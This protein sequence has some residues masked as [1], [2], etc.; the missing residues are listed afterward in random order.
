MMSPRLVAYRWGDVK[1]WLRERTYKRTTQ[2]TKQR[3][4]R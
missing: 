1:Q 2:Y 4:K 3:A